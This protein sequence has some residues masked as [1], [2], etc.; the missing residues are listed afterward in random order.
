MTTNHLYLL[1]EHC[2]KMIGHLVEWK[3]RS[4]LGDGVA[5][6]CGLRCPLCK[7]KMNIVKSVQVHFTTE[8]PQNEKT[9]KRRS[10]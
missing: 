1:S 3:I 5:C 4:I 6:L 10:R 8:K 9:K 7:K 2:R